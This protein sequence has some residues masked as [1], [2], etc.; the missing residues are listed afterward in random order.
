M[1]SVSKV[2]RAFVKADEHL[3]ETLASQASVAIDN[4]RLF[5]EINLSRLNLSLAYDATIEGWSKAVDF[6]DKETEG[7]SKRVTELTWRIARAYGMSQEALVNIRWGALLHD[8]GKMGVP[9]RDSL[10]SSLSYGYRMEDHE[11]TPNICL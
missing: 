2:N 10:Q 8:I 5:S 7:H 9:D 4:A 3:L 6:R 1:P 11:E